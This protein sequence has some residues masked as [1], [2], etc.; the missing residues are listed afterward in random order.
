MSTS[1]S[2]L[3]HGPYKVSAVGYTAGTLS[4]YAG[5]TVQSVGS[6]ASQFPVSQL[7]KTGANAF[8]RARAELGGTWATDDT[9]TGTINGHATTYE[10]LA[11]SPTPT[12]LALG[13]AAAI[14]ADGTSSLIVKATAI[15]DLVEVQALTAGAT[16]EYTFTVSKS[17][18]SGT[19]VASSD[20]LVIDN[21]ANAYQAFPNDLTLVQLMLRKAFVTGSGGGSGIT[22]DATVD[23]VLSDYVAQYG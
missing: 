10:T 18:T 11:G 17:S 23:A 16:G 6:S 21:P 3:G 13:L 4:S 12:S 20:E 19:I 8:A 7:V 2:P 14:N 15:G 9:A 5:L 22:W 1:I